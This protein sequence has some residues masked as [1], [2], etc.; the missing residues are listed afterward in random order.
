MAFAF[1][2]TPGEG[3]SQDDQRAPPSK[4]AP[5]MLVDGL[6][7]EAI[8]CGGDIAVE[9]PPLEF[10]HEF[11]LQNVSGG[12]MKVEKTT[13]SCGCT[14]TTV[15]PGILEPNQS[16]RV[17]VTM[18]VMSEGLKAE[19]VWVQF[20]DGKVQS[21]I[22]YAYG[23]SGG[24][25]YSRPSTFVMPNDGDAVSFDLI[26]IQQ[27]TGQEPD[28]PRIPSATGYEL[29]AGP[30]AMVN[31]TARDSGVQGRWVA[32]CKLRA[33]ARAVGNSSD[34]FDVTVAG[35]GKRTIWIR[36]YEFGL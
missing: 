4:P 17:P 25:V 32:N 23:R 13:V 14:R 35:I 12:P 34:A 3:S 28:A 24:K 7:G 15:E 8:H 26:V 33:V 36:R 29:E 20:G 6:S 18:R 31:P 2:H 16:L 22:M 10:R 11:V 1:L 27:D 5:P 21:V 19:K 30:W 9:N